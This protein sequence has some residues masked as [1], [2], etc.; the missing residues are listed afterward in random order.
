MSHSTTN[1]V[2]RWKGGMR[3]TDM[4]QGGLFSY[5]SMERVPPTHRLRRVRAL[6]DE[7]LDAMSRDFDR[8]YA[9][10]G[11]ES[12]APERLVRAPVT[13]APS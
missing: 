12:V 13:S 5:V 11:R 1:A 4:D 8:I 7:A 6:L 10:G 3:G 9:D 2:T